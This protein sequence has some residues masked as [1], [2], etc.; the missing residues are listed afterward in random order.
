MSNP[1][2]GVLQIVK[3]V[4]NI[5]PHSINPC[6]WSACELYKYLPVSMANF[7]RIHTLYHNVTH[8]NI[9]AAGTVHFGH[10]VRITMLGDT[11]R[12]ALFQKQGNP[13]PPRWSISYN[14]EMRGYPE[15][16]FEAR[17]PWSIAWE[18]SPLTAQRPA[19]PNSNGWADDSVTTMVYVIPI[20]RCPVDDRSPKGVKTNGLSYRLYIRRRLLQR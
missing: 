12:N 20:F 4:P 16:D 2:I 5:S 9:P 10:I 17:L 3:G 14:M 11:Q 18:S 1:V 13:C 7:S 6:I 15:E 8:R 19:G